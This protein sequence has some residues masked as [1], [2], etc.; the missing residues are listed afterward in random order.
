[1][2]TYDV[3]FNLQG[4]DTLEETYNNAKELMS[5][6]VPQQDL[7]EAQVT[8]FVL[9]IPDTIRYQFRITG[10][11]NDEIEDNGLPM[12]ICSMAADEWFLER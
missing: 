9:N 10:W 8:E 2:I 4:D 5:Y 1:M 11:D 7:S 6:R 3:D 12:L